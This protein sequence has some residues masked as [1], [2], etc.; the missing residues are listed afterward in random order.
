M[1]DQAHEDLT[2][3]Q[4]AHWRDSQFAGWFAVSLALACRSHPEEIRAALASVFDLRQVEEDGRRIM[5][6]FQAQAQEAAELRF[7]LADMQKQFERLEQ[8]QINHIEKRADKP[9]I[10]SR[11]IGGKPAEASRR[12]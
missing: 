10:V 2:V 3:Q 7:R 6:M 8:R 4:L 5:A 12:N 11:T 1:M 9:R